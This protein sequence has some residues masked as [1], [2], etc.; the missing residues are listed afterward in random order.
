MELQNLSRKAKLKMIREITS[1]EIHVING[2]IIE[3]GA[4]VIKKGEELFLND[5]PVTLEKLNSAA[6]AVVILPEN[7]RE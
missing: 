4:T 1:G 7:G 2:Q 3:S 5:K 6:K